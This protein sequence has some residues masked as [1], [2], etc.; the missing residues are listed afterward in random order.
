MTGG[1]LAPSNFRPGMIPTDPPGCCRYLRESRGSMCSLPLTTT[2]VK[3]MSRMSHW[4]IDTFRS[5]K[6]RLNPDVDLEALMKDI[7][8]IGYP[9]TT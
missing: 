3:S 2:N 7:S 8:E 9:E 1:P 4:S 5:R 6:L